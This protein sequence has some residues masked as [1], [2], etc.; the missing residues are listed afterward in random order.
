MVEVRKKSEPRK[1]NIVGWGI[2][3]RFYTE[4]CAAVRLPYLSAGRRLGP[5]KTFSASPES[6]VRSA[7]PT[8]RL[9]CGLCHTFR[10]VDGHHVMSREGQLL[11]SGRNHFRKDFGVACT[12]NFYSSIKLSIF[13]VV[14][15]HAG[16]CRGTVPFDKKRLAWLMKKTQ[17]A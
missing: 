17:H 16:V 10:K 15:R 5:G 6:K 13:V 1:R 2:V 3:E 4:E 9:L 7:Q 8:P 12:R 14:G 11:L